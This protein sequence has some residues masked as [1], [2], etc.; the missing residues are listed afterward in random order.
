MASRRW[1]T[2]LSAAAVGGA[3][4]YTGLGAAML[5]P[6]TAQAETSATAEIV[7]DI[8][9]AT[10]Y[11]PAAMDDNGR[12]LGDIV[13][14]DPAAPVAIVEYASLTCPHCASFHNGSLPELT[15]KYIET[16]KVKLI[17]RE[18]YFDQF[19]LLATAVAR[20]GGGARYEKFLDVFF[21]QQREWTEGGDPAQIRDR[22]RRIGLL[23]GM[24]PEQV[25]GCMTDRAYHEALIAFYQ[26]TSG[27]DNV[28]STPYF[29]VNGQEVRGSVSA[30]QMSATIDGLL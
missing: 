9:S 17:M 5:T 7:G 28:R 21:K 24:T 12:V 1:M 18:V 4:M 13:I 29:L 14:G 20:C 10:D 23:G 15:E 27:A 6:A 2:A 3:L 11:E 19:G 22:I 25:D 26:K 8:G 30:D 16:G